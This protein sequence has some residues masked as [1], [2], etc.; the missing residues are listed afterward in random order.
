MATY[1]PADGSQP[2]NTRIYPTN[3]QSFSLQELYQYTN[4]GPIE[5]LSLGDGRLM[6]CNEEAKL[7]DEVRK[8]VRASEFLVFPSAGE[9]R[10]MFAQ[11]AARGEMVFFV[12][13]LPED[14]NA[15]ADYIAG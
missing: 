12:G 7:H 13:D 4:G 1:I 5:M 9:M 11:Y 15:P 6:V 8:N 2:I 10:A 14:D 3:G